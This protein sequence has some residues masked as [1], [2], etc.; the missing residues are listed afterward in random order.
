ME[1]HC[2]AVDL[3]LYVIP[4]F[5]IDTL[6]TYVIKSSFSIAAVHNISLEEEDMGVS[7]RMIGIRYIN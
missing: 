5:L 1:K 4:S 7:Y 6:S 2:D 3:N